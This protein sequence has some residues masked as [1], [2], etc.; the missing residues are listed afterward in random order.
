MI[1]TVFKSYIHDNVGG[2]DDAAGFF[3]GCTFL[4]PSFVIFWSL[5][6]LSVTFPF[7][8][9]YLFLRILCHPCFTVTRAHNV[10]L[11]SKYT[12]IRTVVPFANFNELYNVNEFCVSQNGILISRK[13]SQ[14]HITYYSCKNLHSIVRELL[15]WGKGVKPS[16]HYPS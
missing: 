13:K 1:Q 12:V 5:S 16:F 8:C 2:D 6:H 10:L 9:H 4:V 14:S 15:I 7:E 11:N 3:L